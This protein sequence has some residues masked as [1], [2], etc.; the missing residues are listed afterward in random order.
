METSIWCK[1]LKICLKDSHSVS[2]GELRISVRI[3]WSDKT[4]RLI[5][6][7]SILNFISRGNLTSPVQHHFNSEAWLWQHHDVGVRLAAGTRRLIKVEGKLKQTTDILNGIP[8]VQFSGPQTGSKVHLPKTHR[9]DIREG[10][11]DNSVCP[12]GEKPET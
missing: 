7:A 12:R 5:R 6:L 10:L 2:V 1:T 11:R 3:V 8:V 4:K 9:E